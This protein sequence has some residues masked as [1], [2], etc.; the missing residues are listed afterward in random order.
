M[1]RRGP[2]D[3]REPLNPKPPTPKQAWTFSNPAAKQRPLERYWARLRPTAASTVARAWRAHAARYTL[4]VGRWRAVSAA[5]AARLQRVFRGHRERARLPLILV[6]FLARRE[7]RA[8]GSLGRAFRCHRAR[9]ALREQHSAMFEVR[10]LPPLDALFEGAPPATPW[11]LCLRCAPCHLW[12]LCSGG[13]P[14]PAPTR[15]REGGGGERGSE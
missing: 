11:T 6:G 14:L 4:A 12:T 5:A 8:A 15:G 3:Q 13:H 10:P 2:F 9:A 1:E 7:A